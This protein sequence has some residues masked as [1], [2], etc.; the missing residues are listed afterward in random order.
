MYLFN[1]ANYTCKNAAI[2]EIMTKAREPN[3]DDLRIF[4]EVSRKR[5]LADA[6]AALGMD[7]TT[8]S[9]R[10]QRLEQDLDTTLFERSRRGHQLT[11][12]G[13]DLAH[14]AEIAE[15][16]A[17]TAAE[18]LSGKDQSL[19]GIV[20][21]NV[22][23]GFGGYFVAP[24][25]K[26]FTDQHPA[27]EVEL[28]ASANFLNVSQRETDIAVHLA[29]PQTGNLVVRKLTDYTLRLYASREYIETHAAVHDISDLRS[30]TLVGYI[31]DLIYAPELKYLNQVV[32]DQT[33]RIRSSSIIAQYQAVKAGAGIGIMH[34]F[35]ADPVDELVCV[36]PDSI[37]IE[38]T[39]WLI[40]PESLR[41][42]A[43]IR[44]MSDFL[45]DITR[46]EQNLLLGT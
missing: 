27:I 2:G 17:V 13:H 1:F 23:E 8:V 20:R 25:L 46:R 18:K 33:A 15:S 24:R 3:W 37:H 26:E 28:V 43:R 11:P 35:M 22:A 7:Q 41:N 42:V 21:V 4:L 6:S 40:Y 30:H 36:L 39:F 5:R 10:L 14:Y 44:A 45:I 34:C 9:R 29:R 32:P 16:A 19:S 12:A 38:R 31:D